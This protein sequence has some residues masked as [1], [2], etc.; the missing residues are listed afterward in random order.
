MKRKQGRPRKGDAPLVPWQEVDKLLVFGET[1]KDEKTG[2]EA[3]RYPSFADLGARYGVSRSLIG[4]YATR[5]RCL[6][7]R[8]ENSIREQVQYEREVI[9]RRAKARALSTDQAIEII[10]DYLFRFK[11]ALE[12]GRVR[13][14]NAGDFNQMLRLKEFVQGRADSRQ[15]LQ[16]TLS[17]EE[18]QA[19]HE[20]LR[21]MIDGL[22][23]RAGEA[24]S[25]GADE[26]ARAEGP[27]AASEEA[28]H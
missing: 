20:R 17:L 7:R 5:H 3:L 12:D 11:E 16:G 24:T 22:G 2:I 13:F 14:D 6:K 26:P 10:D 19:R 28:V 27:S 9:K 1:A 25:R 18:I 21:E 4:K 15:E 8:E 23:G